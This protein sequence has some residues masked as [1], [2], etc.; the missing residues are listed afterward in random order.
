M[1]GT[2]LVSMTSF[3]GQIKTGA[4]CRSERL[5]KYNQVSGRT[6]ARKASSFRNQ[7]ML[8][9]LESE[10]NV[11]GCSSS[12][13]RKSSVMPQSTPE[14]SSGHQWSPTKPREPRV[15][16]KKTRM[17]LVELLVRCCFLIECLYYHNKSMVLFA[18]EL[19]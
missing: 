2:D 12:G 14:Q 15:W 8:T 13:S 5:A 1:F 17:F 16:R 3:Q 10:P 19:H 6:C 11:R 7:V 4:P 18:G 9:A